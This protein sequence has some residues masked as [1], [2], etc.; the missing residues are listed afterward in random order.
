MAF[1]RGFL[2]ELSAR[3]D[4]LD[5]VSRYV[6]LKKSGSN[7]FGLCPFHNEKSASFSVSPDK[8]IYHCFG[9][10]AGGG[11]INFIMRAEGLEFP[12]AVRFLAN[13]AGMQVPEDHADPRAAHRRE[14]LLALSRDAGRFFYDQLWAPEHRA[15]QEYFARRG[16]VRPVMNRFGLGYAPNSFSA[17]LD[18]MTA[19]G[20]TKEELLDAGLV[21]KSEKGHIYDRFRNRVMFPIIDLRGQVIAFGGRVMDDSKP[22][23]LNSPETTIF[24]KSRNLFAL[25]LAKKTK[26][27]YFILAEGYMDVIALH[28]AGF[29]SAVASLG[30]SLT[31]EQARLIARYTKSVVISYDAD[32]AGQAAAQRAID[33][34]KRADLS[35]KVLRIPG[36]KDPDE[37]I[38]EKGADAY[39]RL[40]EAS[41][42]HIAYR[43][44]AI[45]AKYDL[46]EDE[47]RVAFLQDAAREL[48]RI[49][50]A[51]EREVYIGRAAN[52]ARVSVDAMQVEVKRQLA[53]RLKKQ[54][55]AERREIRAPVTAAQPRDR[56]LQYP[57]VRSARAE[58]GIIQLVFTD[59]TLLDYLEGKLTPDEFTAPVLRKIYEYARTLHHEGH[60]VTATACEGYL[61]DNELSHLAL[62]LGEPVTAMRREQALDDY[63]DTIKTQRARSAAASASDGEDPLEAFARR[64]REKKS[65]GGNRV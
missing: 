52:M 63:I 47:T 34:L 8:Q 7:Y 59:E 54:K 38:K 4:I 21:S 31:E 24:H 19:K 23:Y 44:D 30:T 57:D 20:Y 37:F 27:E 36:A 65:Y 42:N 32:G 41:E 58:E 10:G 46:D 43:L 55:T 35:V 39:R 16:L 5:I 56:T 33:I 25:N 1:D 53:I 61:E 15:E 14:R 45:A 13:Q 6:Q 40:I 64:Q 22:K 60:L 17:L 3:S 28:Q 18:A 26:A 50:G 49:D 51:I 12:D 48:A 2:D 11:V 9:C 62:L 29:D